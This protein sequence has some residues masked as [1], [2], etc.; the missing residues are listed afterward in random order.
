MFPIR[1]SAPAKTILIGEHAVNRGQTALAV[2]LGL[3]AGCTLTASN[4]HTY[5]FISDAHQTQT[6]REEIIELGRQ[7]DGWRADQ[8]YAAIQQLAA[9]D[10][11]APSKYVLAALGERLP[12]SLTI[13][14]NSAIPQSMGLGSGGALFVALATALTRLAGYPDTPET[15][16]LI[17]QSAHRGDIIAHG[18]IASGLDTQTSFYGGAIRY[19]AAHEGEPIVH[20]PGMALVVGNTGIFAATSAVNGRVRE[21]LAERPVRLHYFHEIGLL[22]RHAEQALASGDW[23]ELGRLM[24]LNQLILER[25]GVSCP[26]LEALNEAAL[27]AGAF[28]A[29]LAGSGGGG[30]MVALTLP[31]RVEAVAEAITAAGG[32]AIVAP[33]GV[34]GV[35]VMTSDQLNIG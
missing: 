30:I 6:T 8:D 18:G 17:R 2:S 28:G 9:A 20:A 11:F 5:N 7:I 29:K 21:W 23:P 14:F 34:P 27:A 25:I 35:Q 19:T 26:E 22:S 31:E 32:T 33:I 4:S 24:N 1:T 13:T 12:S 3:Y 10:F 15:Q 16:R